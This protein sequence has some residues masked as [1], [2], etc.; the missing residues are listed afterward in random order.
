MSVFEAEKQAQ[1]KGIIKIFS[2]HISDPKP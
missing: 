2:G 1:K